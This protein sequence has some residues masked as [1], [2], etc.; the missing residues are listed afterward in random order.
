M[1]T[2]CSLEEREV[3]MKTMTMTR[4]QS[5]TRLSKATVR[6]LEMQKKEVQMSL[7]V[8]RKVLLIKTRYI[9]PIHISSFSLTGVSKTPM[10]QKDAY[11]YILM[12]R[13]IH[14]YEAE[15]E[16]KPEEDQ[17]D[18]EELDELCMKEGKKIPHDT[19][20]STMPEN[21]WVLMR[22]AWIKY[23]T[24]VRERGYRSPDALG[25]YIYNDFEGYGILELVE[26]QVSRVCHLEHSGLSSISF[27]L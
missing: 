12:R 24:V 9:I 6:E 8:K 27:A 26:T 16:G 15:N 7:T 3:K 4:F 19:A 20:A 13:P 18:E 5:L 21:K 2:I 25:M 17:L 22:G 1:K 23:A 14:D 10:D 11:E